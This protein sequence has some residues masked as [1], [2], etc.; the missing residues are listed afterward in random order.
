MSLCFCIFLCETICGET[1]LYHPCLR[2]KTSLSVLF[3]LLRESKDTVSQLPPGG[4]DKQSRCSFVFVFFYLVMQCGLWPPES[5][6]AASL[7]HVPAITI[8]KGGKKKPDILL[9]GN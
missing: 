3:S 5:L 9:S 8:L 7:S 1:K 2:S 6:D 4:V